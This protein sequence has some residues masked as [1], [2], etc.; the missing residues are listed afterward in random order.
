VD[1]IEISKGSG[2]LRLP[3]ILSLIVTMGLLGGILYLT[4]GPNKSPA[5]TTPS[6]IAETQANAAA[7]VCVEEFWK[8][9]V[10]ALYDF[11]SE[12]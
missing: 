11:Y 5:A 6:T 7:D 2:D 10:Q 3:L 12:H 1:Q 4:V 9:Q 8:E